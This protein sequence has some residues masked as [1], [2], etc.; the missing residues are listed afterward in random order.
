MWSF[1]MLKN[2]G[3]HLLVSRISLTSRH[4]VNCVCVYYVCIM[5]VYRVSCA[6]YICAWSHSVHSYFVG[7]Y[8]VIVGVND[9]WFH[10]NV[11]SQKLKNNY[12]IVDAWLTH[13]SWFFFSIDRSTIIVEFTPSKNRLA[14]YRPPR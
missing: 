7:R 9:V 2:S 13:K 4:S 10:L 14:L 12:N 11:K 3:V 8:L 1:K 6:V 5:C